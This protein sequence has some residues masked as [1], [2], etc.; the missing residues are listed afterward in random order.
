MERLPQ[1]IILYPV[2]SEKSVMGKEFNK[3]SFKV[4]KNANKVEIK[5]AI[6]TLFKVK[7]DKVNTMNCIGKNRRVGVHA[8]ITSEWKKAIV[9]LKQGE[10]IAFFEGM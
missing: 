7:V 1:D 2:I 6:E 4:I 9:T 10:K 3:Y 8:G 5:K